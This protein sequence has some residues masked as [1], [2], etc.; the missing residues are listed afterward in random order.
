ML[1]F[2]IRMGFA[3][4]SFVACCLHHNDVPL[5]FLGFLGGFTL[6]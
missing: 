1:A 4:Y 2:S 3:Y 6:L 5:S